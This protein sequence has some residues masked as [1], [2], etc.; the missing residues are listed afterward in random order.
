ESQIE[1]VVGQ[2]FIPD[3]KYLS[4]VSTLGAVF[5]TL[6]R[7]GWGPVGDRFAYKVPLCCLNLFY[8]VILITLPFIPPIP[9]AGK[10]LYALWVS[11]VYFCVAGNFVL[12]P[13]GISRAFGHKHF[14]ANYGIVFSAFVSV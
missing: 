6:A 1:E 2:R 4:L 12:L 7:I 10:Y 13:F 11:F 3:D 8:G 14:A 9:V 5:N